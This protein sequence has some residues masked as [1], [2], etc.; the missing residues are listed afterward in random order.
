MASGLGRWFPS[1]FTKASA[2]FHGAAAVA[3][4]WD[5]SLLPIVVSGLVANHLILS[6]V[7][8]VPRGS[9][10]GPNI[11]RLPDAAAALGHVAL[12]IDDG[13]DAAVTPAVL[14][15]LD[16]YKVRATFFAIGSQI[17]AAPE[18]AR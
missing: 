13:P 14:E 7:G 5:S 6:T 10:L 2:A 15:I 9:L 1:A 12:T 4:A 17:L 3:L 11:T 8:L 16:R 18:L